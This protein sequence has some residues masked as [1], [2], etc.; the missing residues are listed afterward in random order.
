MVRKPRNRKSGS[1]D[2]F[3]K[4]PSKGRSHARVHKSIYSK[5]PRKNQRSNIPTQSFSTRNKISNDRRP[6]PTSM[7]RARENYARERS[8]DLLYDLRH[9][10]GPYSKLLRDYHLDTRTAHKYLGAALRI[11]RGGRVQA[12]KSDRLIRNLKFPTY[13]GDIPLPVRGSGAATQL[14]EFFHDRGKLLGNKLTHEKFEAKWRGVIIA[15]QEVFADAA[16]ILLRAHAGDLKIDDL[17]AS[18]GGAE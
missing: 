14:S 1:A 2:S 10:D 9:K 12:S 15:G 13:S 6:I 16:T 4:N 8:L 17:Y 5:N 18:G 11:G 3:S 7:Q